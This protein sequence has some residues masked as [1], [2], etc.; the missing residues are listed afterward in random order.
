[1]WIDLNEVQSAYYWHLIFYLILSY[2]PRENVLRVRKVK[3]VDDFLRM[4]LGYIEQEI[5]DLGDS[6]EKTKNSGIAATAL[7]NRCPHKGSRKLVYSF[8]EPSNTIARI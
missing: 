7:C 4:V 5:R 2:K 3:Y 1:M 6:L 8:A